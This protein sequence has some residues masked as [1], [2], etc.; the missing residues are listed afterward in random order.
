MKFWMTPLF[1][2]L[3]LVFSPD[4]RAE[5]S[6]IKGIWINNDGVRSFKED[7]KTEAYS[8]FAQSLGEI[9]FSASV[10]FNLAT[11]Y[12]FNKESEKA[13]QEY[14]E[15]LKLPMSPQLKFATLFNSAVAATELKQ[16]DK[17]LSFYQSALELNPE[18][19]EVKTNIE[20]L[21]Q[22][23]SGGGDKDKDK[24]D[25]NKND[26]KDQKDQ[27]DPQNKK[28]QGQKPPEQKPDQ[29][30]QDQKPHQP[31]PFKSDELSQQDVNRIM[32]E[33]KRQEEQV[34]A[35]YQNEKSTD[36]PLDKDW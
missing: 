32:E 17:A 24:K 13:L 36:V 28:D 6:Q 8:H 33:I 30:G 2:L 10:H 14:E 9:P 11:T 22:S 18:S 19:L 25:Q 4:V 21:I 15:T 27:K 26:P 3:V 29:K 7:R 31:K 1:L 34:R 5:G 20:L 12:L 23:Q 35:K 16:V